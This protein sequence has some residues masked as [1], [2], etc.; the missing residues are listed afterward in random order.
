MHESAGTLFVPALFV[1]LSANPADDLGAVR[2]V[3]QNRNG[4][5]RVCLAQRPGDHLRDIVLADHVQMP[6]RAFMARIAAMNAA[7]F[8]C[9]VPVVF[10]PVISARRASFSSAAAP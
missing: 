6:M 3:V 10:V 4:I 1:I 2:L 9:A 7:L 8:S 5:C